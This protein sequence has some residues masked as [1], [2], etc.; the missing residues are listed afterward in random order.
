LPLKSKAI[1]EEKIEEETGFWSHAAF[2]NKAID[3]DCD[4]LLDLKSLKRV[5]LFFMSCLGFGSE[6][7]IKE[8]MSFLFFIVFAISNMIEIFEFWVF[9]PINQLKDVPSAIQF[10]CL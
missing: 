8:K 9:N 2:T 4:Q 1:V 6:K 5:S 3:F 10:H 7:K